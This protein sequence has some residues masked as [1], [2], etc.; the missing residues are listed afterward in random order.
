MP[1]EIIRILDELI[2]KFKNA[3][4]NEKDAEPLKKWQRL[5]RLLKR[6]LGP[7]EFCDI[8]EKM[9]LFTPIFKHWKDK[10]YERSFDIA[11]RPLEG[12]RKTMTKLKRQ[13]AKKF[14]KALRKKSKKVKKVT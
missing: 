6:Y 7:E 12:A 14:K 5:R 3:K 4:P 10:G 1:T 2:A 8:K 9:D 13:S 11:L